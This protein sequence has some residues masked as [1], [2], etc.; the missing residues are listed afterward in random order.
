MH[1]T[2]APSHL[3]LPYLDQFCHMFDILPTPDHPPSFPSNPLWDFSPSY[4]LLY[5]SILFTLLI[6]T[7]TP[8]YTLSISPSKQCCLS[9]IHPVTSLT[10]NPLPTS[11]RVLWEAWAP[12]GVQFLKLWIGW[13]RELA[14]QELKDVQRQAGDEGDDKDLPEEVLG[15]DKLPVWWWREKGKEG[16]LEW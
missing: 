15:F 6:H 16:M 8:R 11:S 4:A 10:S 5:R 1:C 7:L 14:S 9:Y 13:W 3:T 2:S 12:K